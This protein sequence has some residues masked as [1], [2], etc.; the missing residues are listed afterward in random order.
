MRHINIIQSKTY[1]PCNSD[2]KILDRKSWKR[3]IE[4]FTEKQR[5][6]RF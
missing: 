2:A 3:Y 5:V 6:N 4:V 1:T